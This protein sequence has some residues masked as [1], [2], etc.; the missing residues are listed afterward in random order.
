MQKSTNQCFLQAISL[1][2]SHLISNCLVKI[3]IFYPGFQQPSANPAIAIKS[4]NTLCQQANKYTEWGKTA[5]GG[6][7]IFQ[8]GDMC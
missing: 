3:E 1:K 7:G 5:Q 8:G 4:K 6:G 2:L